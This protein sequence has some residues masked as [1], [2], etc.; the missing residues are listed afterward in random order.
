LKA[1]SWTRTEALRHAIARLI[2]IKKLELQHDPT[3]TPQTALTDL[4]TELLTLLP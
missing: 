2:D 3:L 4:K 1:L